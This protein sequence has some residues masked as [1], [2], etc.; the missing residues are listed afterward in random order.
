MRNEIEKLSAENQ[1]LKQELLKMQEELTSLDSDVC[2][3][4]NQLSRWIV[5][6]FK[7]GIGNM[8]SVLVGAEDLGEFFRRFDNI[9]FFI[10]YYNN[11]IIETQAL[12]TQRKQEERSMM[13]KQREIQNLEEQA[14]WPWIKLQTMPGKTKGA[15]TC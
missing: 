4:Q 12:I 13:E 6:S 8:L 7:G 10:E 14:K 11:I 2:L 9:V 1:G 3:R 5:F 15:A